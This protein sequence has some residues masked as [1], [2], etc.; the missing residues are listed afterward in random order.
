MQSVDRRMTL[1]IR[2][3]DSLTKEDEVQGALEGVLKLTILR[4]DKRGLKLAVVTNQLDRI[5]IRFTCSSVRN[6]L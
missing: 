6:R 3:L 4:L 1:K 5:K 2:D